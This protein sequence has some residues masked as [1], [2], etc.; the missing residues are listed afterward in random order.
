M[1]HMT[2]IERRLQKL[3]RKNRFLS[4]VIIMFAALPFL[5]LLFNQAV[6]PDVNAQMFPGM[7]G[8]ENQGGGGFM[9]AEERD[10]DRR[11]EE[12]RAGEGQS[13]S[14][15][16]SLK[17]GMLEVQAIV[18]RDGQGHVRGMWGVENGASTLAV[19]SP[20]QK[21]AIV[22]TTAGNVA[23]LELK[24]RED[25]TL[26]LG[27]TPQQNA[28][29]A[30]DPKSRNA[31]F[32]GAVNGDSVMELTGTTSS[33][34]RLSGAKTY[35]DMKGGDSS[36]FKMLGAKTGLSLQQPGDARVTL[37][38]DVDKNGLV[39]VNPDGRTT[40]SAATSFNKTVVD[41]VSP[42]DDNARLALYPKKDAD[43]KKGKKKVRLGF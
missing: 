39:F 19:S 27:I 5:G 36:E 25:R 22:L 11:R 37:S 17:V 8:G 23:T 32:V 29:Y 3:E 18:L 33:Q 2:E 35:M 31:M 21:P 1:T 42:S 10:R 28:L 14:E 30:K 43:D 4:F 40:Y 16:E 24:D 15:F 38:S 9:G 13:A 20:G 34:I 12:D 6:V 7:M 41:L 26:G